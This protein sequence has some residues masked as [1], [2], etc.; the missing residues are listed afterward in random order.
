[1]RCY[2]WTTITARYIG[3]KIL[4]FFGY[5]A[6]YFDMP[7]GDWK[8]F[9]NIGRPL[10]KEP[11]FRAS[12]KAACYSDLRKRNSIKKA[13]RSLESEKRSRASKKH[14]SA[15]DCVPALFDGARSFFIPVRTNGS[16]ARFAGVW[17][18]KTGLSKM[19]MRPY[20]STVFGDS[21]AAPKPRAE[22]SS[23]SAPATKKSQKPWEI[24]VSGTFAFLFRYH[25]YSKTGY[26]KQYYVVKNVVR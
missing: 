7:C 4:S 16:T 2:Y 17:R 26:N 23:P 22:G 19:P 13:W 12:K 21:R 25:Y 8:S 20:F 11:F 5:A 10:Q 6:H 9:E 14:Q 15:F 24:R 1:M 18:F 3:L